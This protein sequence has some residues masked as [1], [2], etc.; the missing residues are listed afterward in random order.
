MRQRVFLNRQHNA[1]GMSGPPAFWP[2]P[3]CSPIGHGQDVPSYIVASAPPHSK[4]SSC[5]SGCRVTKSRVELH[6]EHQMASSVSIDCN[7]VFLYAGR[8]V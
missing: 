4:F 3:L 5:S 7:D 8:R 1:K 2:P 6:L